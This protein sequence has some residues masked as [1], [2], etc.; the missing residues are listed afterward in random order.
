MGLRFVDENT[1]SCSVVVK[2]IY[3]NLCEEEFSQKT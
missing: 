2:Q 3:I 1:T